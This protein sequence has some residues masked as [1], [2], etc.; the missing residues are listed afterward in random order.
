MFR[1]IPAQEY[2]DLFASDRSHMLKEDKITYNAPPPSYPPI[3]NESM[4]DFY[5]VKASENTKFSFVESTNNINEFIDMKS[6]NV[7]GTIMNLDD[8][9]R[10]L[11]IN[12]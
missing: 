8:F 11:E 2:L 5:P 9:R 3:S 4:N 6:K 10:F 7:P 12:N 1:V